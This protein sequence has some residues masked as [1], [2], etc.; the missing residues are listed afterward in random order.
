MIIVFGG[1]FNPPT[2]AH[3]Q[4]VKKIAS[5][6]NPSKF[7]IM[8]VGDN[9]SWKDSF[10]SFD[11]RF[12]MLKLAFKDKKYEISDLENQ[13]TYK[14]TYQSLLKIKETYKSDVYFVMGA[15]NIE[16]FDEW[17]N[18][19]KLINEFYFIIL[20]RKTIDL[21]KIIDQKY[22]QYQKRIIIL[23]CS[24]NIAA[25]DFRNNPEKKDLLPKSVYS[26]IKKHNLYGVK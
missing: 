23:D 4:I 24:I 7:L 21:N 20:T 5:L 12:E 16:K 2:I 17:I 18:F 13:N 8:P 14:G 9:Y 22:R 1:T 6:Y 26:Y 3:Q 15:D 19:D 11:R 10:A 25:S